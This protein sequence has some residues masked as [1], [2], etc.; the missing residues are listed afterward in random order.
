[1]NLKALSDVLLFAWSLF[2]LLLLISPQCFLQENCRKYIL[3]NL[4]WIDLN[5]YVRLLAKKYLL[6]RFDKC[7]SAEHQHLDH[8]HSLVDQSFC[9]SKLQ[10]GLIQG[11]GTNKHIYLV[12]YK[13]NCTIV[14]YDNRWMQNHLQMFG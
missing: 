3:I 11:I 4:N 9:H 7:R 13:S 12:N 8:I 1:M 6:T 14:L 5:T 2:I 10:L